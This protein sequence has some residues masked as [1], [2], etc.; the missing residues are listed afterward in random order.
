MRLRGTLVTGTT[1]SLAVT[2]AWALLSSLTIGPA[3]PLH[4]SWRHP[5]SS[6]LL[7]AAA[8]LRRVP[9]PPASETIPWYEDLLPGRFENDERRSMLPAGSP[10]TPAIPAFPWLVASLFPPGWERSVS[11]CGPAGLCGRLALAGSGQ[12]PT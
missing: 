11:V 4:L 7:L 6:Y 5:G 12:P 10:V 3:G 8:G 2:A 9:R 1:I